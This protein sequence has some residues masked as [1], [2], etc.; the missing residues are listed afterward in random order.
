MQAE[1][2]IELVTQFDPVDQLKDI[3]DVLELHNAA[4][5]VTDQAFPQSCGEDERAAIAAKIPAISAASGRYFASLSEAGLASAL[6]GLD[7]EYYDD[8]LVLFARHKLYER[9]SAVTMLSALQRAGVGLSEL[10]GNQRLVK[11]YDEDVRTLTLS[12][13]T[14]AELLIGKLLV[15][16]DRRQEL[17]LP[18]S[19]STTD[20]RALIDQYLD[21]DEAN[22]N[23][24]ALVAR[25]RASRDGVI[26]YKTKLKAQRKH[27]KWS[28]DFFKTNSG[29]ETG[30]EVAIVEAQD[31]EVVETL[32]GLVAR[33]SYS[34]RWL[35]GTLDMA[36]VLTN[37]IHVFDF[38]DSHSALL[39]MP[40]QPTQ[41]SV[42]ERVMRSAGKEEYQIGAAFQM[43]ETAAFLKTAIYTKF[44]EAHDVPL[45][46]VFAWFCR[47]YVRDEFGV[48]NFRYVPSSS[49]STYL[50]KCRHLFPEMESLVR[51][52]THF[53]ENG[54]IDPDLL[55]LT[56]E[57]VR[58]RDIP[59]LLP[60]KYAYVTDQEDINSIQ[61]LL[62]S[63]QSPIHY[64]NEDLRG[65]DFVR[66]LTNNE[67]HL[68]D[69]A[70]HQKGHVEFLRQQGIVETNGD[71]RIV[72]VNEHRIV[73]L[74]QLFTSG[75]ASYYHYP[76]SMRELIDDMVGK[77][78]LRRSASLL[79]EAE[80]SYFNYKLNQLE[81]SNGPDLRNRYSHGAQADSSD[82]DA[83]Y[84]TY[85]TAQML[86]VA[87]IIM[88]NDDLLLHWERSAGRDKSQ[89]G[90]SH[91]ADPQ[92]G[93]S[94]PEST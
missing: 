12:Q 39:D 11:S 41:L 2:A 19:L 42:L 58:Y 75:A 5:F 55:A 83:H 91:P 85:L 34:K 69:L 93:I 60:G 63:D 59:S 26:D 78:W 30:V 68:D 7:S 89:A 86:L 82:E 74:Q 54:E 32:D 64:I 10:L 28:E 23:F 71:G 43:K 45:E 18:A 9:C 49:T 40:S 84:H 1:R 66:L 33:Y 50:E 17:F 48:L 37:F 47:E 46:S 51:Q 20:Q 62:F 80:A 56:S 4:M 73:V 87:L 14:H 38:A 22:P 15:A 94:E 13:P 72:F 61:F 76:P 67:V 27:D 65:T 92:D 24:V 6:E 35:E 36:S 53:V 77:G 57:Q 79:T 21:W 81:F 88:M 70:E 25:A 29:T 16:D 31:E 3:N 52:F 90:Q 44:L 8:L